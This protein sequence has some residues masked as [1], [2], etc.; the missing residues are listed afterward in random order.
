MKVFISK[1]IPEEIIKLKKPIILNFFNMNSLYHYFKNRKYREK[2]SNENNI[3]F[4][5]SRIISLKLK[6][7][8]QRG[9]SF[10]RRFLMHSDIAKNKKH[11]FIGPN[12]EDLKKISKITG[13]KKKNLKTHNPSYIK[14]IEFSK[15]EIKKISAKIKRFKP[16]F[17]WVCIGSPKQDILSNKLYRGYKTFYFNVGAAMDFLLGKK[18][19]APKIFTKTGT[20]WLYR[21]I[22]DF[23]HT[24]KKVQRSLVAINHLKIVEVR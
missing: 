15:S 16:D 3:N 11:F 7:P 19:E 24:K 4:P 23:N 5:D 14:S 12:E 6:I 8:Q 2:I 10:T 1:N 17:V 21:L 18:K 9:P 20:E 22:T 13:I